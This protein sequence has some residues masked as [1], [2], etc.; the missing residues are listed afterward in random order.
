M[1][2]DGTVM[3]FCGGLTIIWTIVTKY[4]SLKELIPTNKDVQPSFSKGAAF[5]PIIRE[6][7]EH[8]V[9]RRRRLCPSHNI[10]GHLDNRRSPSYLPSRG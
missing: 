8:D 10:I 4:E 3:L 7:I 6:L 1:F 5:D 2:D 9:A